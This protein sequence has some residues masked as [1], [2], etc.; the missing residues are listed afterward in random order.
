MYLTKSHPRSLAHFFLDDAFARDF[1][2]PGTRHQRSFFPSANILEEENGFR[3]EL[4]APGFDKKSFQLKIENK[5]LIIAVEKQEQSEQKS[6]KYTR[7]EFHLNSFKRSFSL[8]DSI[9]EAAIEANYENGI[10]SVLLPK[11]KEESTPSMKTIEV[12]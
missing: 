11:K 6:A 12:K 10:L 2:V 7:K 1:F 9:E 3:I 8:P 5:Q 4:A